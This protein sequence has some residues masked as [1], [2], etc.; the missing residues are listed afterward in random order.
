MGGGGDWRQFA[1][2]PEA[3][4]GYTLGEQTIDT[5]DCAAA[6]RISAREFAQD[7][8]IVV[9]S[10]DALGGC[11]AETLITICWKGLVEKTAFIHRQRTALVLLVMVLPEQRA[12]ATD[13]T[14]TG[15]ERQR[16]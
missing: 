9:G 7:V 2:P 1:S 4:L 13:T 16:G 11:V 10:K 6:I 14:Q 3:P 12:L 8:L 15:S 5:C